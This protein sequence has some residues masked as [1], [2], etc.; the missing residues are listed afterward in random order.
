MISNM[1]Y[2][3]N[4]EDLEAVGKQL[5]KEKKMI[6]IQKETMKDLTLLLRSL[7]L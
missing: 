6:N 3:I 5:Q 7:N 1:G 2:G 4:C